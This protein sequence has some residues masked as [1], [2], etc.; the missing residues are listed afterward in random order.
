M[1]TSNIKISYVNATGNTDFAVVVFT[2]NFN[3]NTPKVYYSAWKILRAQSQVDFVYPVSLGVGVEYTT[4]TGLHRA[5]PFPAELGSTWE[6]SHDTIT[7]T[8]SLNKV[9]NTQANP[10][11]SIVVKNLPP[12]TWSG[13]MFDVGV[14]KDGGLLVVEKDVHVGSQA[15]I[16]LKPKLYFAVVSNMVEGDVFSAMEITSSLTEFDLSD[17]PD[18]LK[19]TLTEVGR[20]RQFKFEGGFL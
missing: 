20:G 19:V 11:G 12:C 16:M 14:Y 2:K 4:S 8:P 6:L 3:V 13:R 5:G 17:Y 18:G 9:A 7:S 1:A 15:V 10:N